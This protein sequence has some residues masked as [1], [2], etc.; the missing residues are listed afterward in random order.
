MIPLF[1]FYELDNTVVFCL[2]FAPLD[3]YFMSL[4]SKNLT[5]WKI[6][7]TQS[8]ILCWSHCHTQK[9]QSP[10]HSHPTSPTGILACIHYL[11][12]QGILQRQP[13]SSSAEPPDWCDMNSAVFPRWK[14]RGGT[15][16]SNPSWYFLLFQS[17]LYISC[18]TC[19]K[20]MQMTL[21]HVH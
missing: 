6:V 21:L 3:L 13:K 4:A 18:S 1:Y 2:Y 20:M 19:L 14:V 7:A 11:D 8:H 9:C 5:V 17:K 10:T 16:H 15:L 12:T